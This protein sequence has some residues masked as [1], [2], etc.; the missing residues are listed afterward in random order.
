MT[1]TD[2]PF[3]CP[4]CDT[5]FGFGDAPVLLN[6]VNSLPF[7]DEPT[8]CCGALL[9]GRLTREG[10]NSV[11]IE[12][13]DWKDAELSDDPVDT[14]YADAIAAGNASEVA[15]WERHMR[16]GHGVQAVGGLVAALYEH[17]DGKDID[18]AG[19]AIELAFETVEAPDGWREKAITTVRAILE[20]LPTPVQGEG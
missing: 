9:T 6:V 18:I 14:S 2:L 5:P 16:D 3:I 19:R 8:P 15:I 17:R 13:D 10:L 4:S 12:I 1:D 11:A 7:A 20:N